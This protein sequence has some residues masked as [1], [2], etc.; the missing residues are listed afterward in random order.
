MLSFLRLERRNIFFFFPPSYFLL[1]TA[2][3]ETRAPN[4][5]ILLLIGANRENQL[6]VLGGMTELGEDNTFAA[7]TAYRFWHQLISF[8]QRMCFEWRSVVCNIN[9]NI[10][11][12]TSS[13]YVLFGHNHTIIIIFIFLWC[14]LIFLA[15]VFTFT[16]SLLCV[17]LQFL[18]TF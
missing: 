2:A 7:W 16:V 15:F 8:S 5:T 14:L 13:V 11:A 12:T 10:D 9:T 17:F 4:S 6:W 1:P 18:L 3:P